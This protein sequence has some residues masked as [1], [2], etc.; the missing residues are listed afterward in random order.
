MKPATDTLNNGIN[1]WTH[2]IAAFVCK[3]GGKCVG[4][5]YAH[6]FCTLSLLVLTKWS[7]RTPI[8]SNELLCPCLYFIFLWQGWRGGGGGGIV[9]GWCMRRER[10][11]EHLEE[12]L[13]SKYSNENFPCIN[14]WWM[15]DMDLDVLHMKY[16][17]IQKNLNQTERSLPNISLCISVVHPVSSCW[18]ENWWE[19]SAFSYHCIH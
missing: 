5:V 4:G 1:Q 15:L 11:A 13:K 18:G 7:F 19:H 16:K 2:T 6:W 9:L 17:I 8:G 10:G 3:G 14:T 12:V